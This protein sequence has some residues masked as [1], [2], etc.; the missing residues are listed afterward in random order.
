ME[1]FWP[2]V[3]FWFDFTWDE[4]TFRKK[5][6]NLQKTS[7]NRPCR[8]AQNWGREETH[9]VGTQSKDEA[10][11]VVEE[12]GIISK[13]P[14]SRESKEGG[15]CTT[16]KRRWNESIDYTLEIHNLF[17]LYWDIPFWGY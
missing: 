6:E 9:T 14:K 7:L 15:P 11:D 17:K 4:T 3:L 2:F 5:T 12:G 8:E 1:M 13:S 16:R 10:D